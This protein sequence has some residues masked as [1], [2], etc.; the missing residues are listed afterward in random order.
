MTTN[1]KTLDD[2]DKSLLSMLSKDR[3][4]NFKIV[5]GM[6]CATMQFLTTRAIV[7]DLHKWGYEHRYCYQDHNE[8]DSAL[9][10]WK[11]GEN[12]AP[13]NWIKLKGVK[14]ERPVDTLNPLWSNK[15]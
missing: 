2:V 13:G 12:Y 6:L 10:I 3:Y 7:C 5:N 4:E 14:D 1:Y 15:E 8:A 9:A 11:T